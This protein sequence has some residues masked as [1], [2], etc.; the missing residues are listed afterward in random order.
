MKKIIVACPIDKGDAGKL[1]IVA[2]KCSV[3][4]LDGIRPGDGGTLTII[5]NKCSIVRNAP[6]RMNMH[7]PQRSDPCPPSFS[8]I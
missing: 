4:P 6:Y 5:A 1:T 3:M 8:P 2:N 7:L